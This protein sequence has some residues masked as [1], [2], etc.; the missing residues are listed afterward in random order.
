MYIA[1]FVIVR[2]NNLADNTGKSLSEQMEER[3]ARSV[4]KDT[5]QVDDN[6][7]TIVIRENSTEKIKRPY[8]GKLLNLDILKINGQIREWKCKIQKN[9]CTV[10]V[11]QRKVYRS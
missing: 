8:Q 9:E 1:I 5:D 3:E 2:E 6:A 7:K 4:I 11:A 10:I